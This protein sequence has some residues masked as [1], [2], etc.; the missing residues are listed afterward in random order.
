MAAS[1][2]ATTLFMGTVWDRNGLLHRQMEHLAAV[3]GGASLRGV[4]SLKREQGERG[5]R[6]TTGATLVR[7]F[8]SAKRPP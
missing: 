3:E 5:K 6:R 4:A 2:N 1:T 8:P 7:L